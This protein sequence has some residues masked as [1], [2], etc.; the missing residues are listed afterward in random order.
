MSNGRAFCY[1][2]WEVEDGIAHSDGIECD[3][4]I[5]FCLLHKNAF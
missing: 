1:G 4:I 3:K 5:N 2:K